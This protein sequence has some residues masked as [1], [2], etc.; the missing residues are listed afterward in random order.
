MEL[1]QKI[2]DKSAKVGIIGLGY[3]GLPLGLEFAIKGFDVI[4][5]DVDE[6]RLLMKRIGVWGFAFFAVKGVF[7]LIF[8]GAL[9]W[10]GMN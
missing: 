7:W 10:Y 5:F 4:G 9:A 3:V 1:V 6:K 8:T 2:K